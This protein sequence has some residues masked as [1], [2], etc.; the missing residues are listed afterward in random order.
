MNNTIKSALKVLITIGFAAVMVVK[1][2]ASFSAATEGVKLCVSTV[3]PSLLPFMAMSSFILKS[4]VFAFAEKALRKISCILFDLPKQS[5]MIFIMSLIGGFPVGAKLISE[6]VKGGQLTQNQGKRMLLF[7]V[8]PGPAFVVNIVGISIIGNMTAG[9]ILLVSICMASLVTGIISR[10]FKI[11]EEDQSVNSTMIS[12]FPLID[13]VYESVKAIIGVCGWIVITSALIGIINSFP[14]EE[15]LKE[16]INILTEV[17]IGCRLSAEQFPLPLTALVLGWSG[18]SVHAQLLPYIRCVGLK[19]RHFAV[20]RI[21]NGVFSMGIS[22]ILFR[23]FPCEI[24]VFSNVG[25]IV[26]RSVSVSAPATAGLL[27]LSAL[28]ILDLAPK[29]KV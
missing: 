16:W 18:I 15:N 29:R 20:G 24:S 14:I 22:F 1:S 5:A 6:C 3:I 11:E 8:N 21:F 2:E 12:E 27:F 28:I 10:R 17:T 7:C 23:V 19:Y 9:I 25:E 4:D 26:P 13:S